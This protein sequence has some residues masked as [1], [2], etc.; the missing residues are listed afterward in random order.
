MILEFIF[1]L[2]LNLLKAIFSLLP[3]IP[4]LPGSFETSLNHVFSVIFNN[5]NLVGL[6]VRIDTIKILVPL[7]LIVVNF[8]HIYHFALWVLKKIPLSVD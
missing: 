5:A 3:D 7:I 4:S 2:I 8:E 1:N 6:F